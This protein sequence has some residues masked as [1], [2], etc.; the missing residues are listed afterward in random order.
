MT[1][2]SLTPILSPAAAMAKLKGLE[3]AGAKPVVINAASAE[4][5]L[6][7]KLGN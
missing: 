1:S 4:Y 3:A 5:L 6:A 2:F 7:L